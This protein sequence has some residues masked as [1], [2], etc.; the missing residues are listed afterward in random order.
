MRRTDRQT[1]RLTERLDRDTKRQNG[2][3]VIEG[4]DLRTDTHKM[5][6]IQR[7]QIQR[8]VYNSKYDYAIIFKRL[9]FIE[10]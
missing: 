1:S 7:D 5:C 4:N 10:Y 2:K 9:W 6:Q 3:V 8:S